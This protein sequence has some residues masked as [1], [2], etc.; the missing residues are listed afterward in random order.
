MK[1]FDVYV[2]YRDSQLVPFSVIGE[3]VEI[4]REGYAIKI[5]DKNIMDFSF[6]KVDR[7]LERS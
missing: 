6:M 4:I 2:N 5:D 7:V 3:K 1:R